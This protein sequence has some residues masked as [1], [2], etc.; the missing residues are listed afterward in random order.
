MVVR[1]VIIAAVA[2]LLCAVAALAVFVLP[3]W[4]GD[5]AVKRITASLPPGSTLSEG[6]ARYDLLSGTLALGD[7]SLRRVNLPPFHAARLTARGGAGAGT[8]VD[9][10]T[11]R[12]VVG[13]VVTFD[14]ETIDRLSVSK[15][16][17]A[18]PPEVTTDTASRSPGG[19]VL[20]WLRVASIGH[21]ELSDVHELD[22]SRLRHVTADRLRASQVG[23]L[24]VEGVSAPTQGFRFDRLELSDAD[25][26]SLVSVFDPRSYRQPRAQGEP[27][28]RLLGR[29]DWAGLET[30]RDVHMHV[31]RLTMTGLVG[32]PFVVAP[33]QGQAD[34]RFAPDL[35][36]ALSFDGIGIDDVQLDKKQQ[37]GAV[38]FSLA[39]LALASYGGGR[40]GDGRLDA[41]SIAAPGEADVTVG[42]F[43]L[44]DLDA[45][46][47]L[48]VAI[49][50]AAEAQ[51]RGIATIGRADFLTRAR[52]TVKLP[53]L[54]MQTVLVAPADGPTVTVA[55]LRLEAAF[56]GDSVAR[57]H[58]TVR[59]LV[60]PFK[61]L[62]W[63]PERRVQFAAFGDTKVVVDLDLA[64][65][66]AAQDI[67]LDNLD[68]TFEKL[69]ELRIS[70]AFGQF[71]RARLDAGEYMSAMLPMTVKRAEARYEDD[72]LVDRLL[73]VVAAGDGSTSEAVRATLVAR[74]QAFSL[75]PDIA[76][77]V[78]DFLRH[79]H[80]LTASMAPTQPV[81]LLG[82]AGASRE[83]LGLKVGA[84]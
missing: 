40:L 75:P 60:I 67:A 10:F 63:T 27:P 2:V 46:K 20:H 65:S 77:A 14:R 74:V 47:L 58:Q 45:G 9:P 61:G 80:V 28:H 54:D 64:G 37:T 81:M 42:S 23:H 83:A 16:V 6:S 59:G 50:A 4:L 70:G 31:G 33:D 51:R 84:N 62:D 29:L 1:R 12:E 44:R 71:D 18:A 26:G 39:H 79:P 17:I 82:I 52:N 8:E 41:L 35:F 19:D 76:R 34:P 78:V 21:L 53:Y 68:V 72:S 69:G 7:V 66:V 32:R 24:V 13:T 30:D 43:E 48:A 5:R 25:V 3:G 15:L 57:V 11:A 49:A 22:G 56:D 36:A 55:G 38:G 73:A